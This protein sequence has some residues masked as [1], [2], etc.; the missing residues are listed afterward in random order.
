MQGLRMKMEIEIFNIYYE[1][2]KIL[3]FTHTPYI[4]ITL[5]YI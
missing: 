4:A 5:V 3:I 1:L 2:L